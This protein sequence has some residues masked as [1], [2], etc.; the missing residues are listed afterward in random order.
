MITTA[1][2]RAPADNDVAP[3]SPRVV[4]SVDDGIERIS[5]FGGDRAEICG[6][7]KAVGHPTWSIYVT[8]AVAEKA[9]PSRLGPI[10]PHL[11]TCNRQHAHLW[12]EFI[13]R[14]YVRAQVR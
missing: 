13:A 1:D 8:T 12:V 5:V 14:L 11:Q 10:P 6:A 2:H 9:G 3:Y 7:F 4:T